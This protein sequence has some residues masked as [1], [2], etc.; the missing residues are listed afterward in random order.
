MNPDTEH[1]AIMAKLIDS[2][3]SISRSSS[4]FYYFQ[5]LTTD[6]LILRQVGM[7]D[8]DAIFVYKSNPGHKK[9][10]RVVQ[11]EYR[12][13]AEDHVFGLL[14]QHFENSSL[15]WILAFKEN[16]DQAIGNI[17]VRGLKAGDMRAQPIL[18][19]S[20][21]L[22]HHARGKGLMN[23]ARRRVIPWLFH[24]FNSMNRIHSEVVDYNTASLAMNE[25]LG[26]TREGILREYESDDAGLVNIVVLS[27]LRNEYLEKRDTK[28]NLIYLPYAEQ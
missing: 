2:K 20:C 6:R 26:F 27:L 16:P 24:Y 15:T 12:Y 25:R 18:E 23:E 1:Q 14:K 8:I 10:P 13:Q 22:A 4:A 11:F 28:G 3:K 19:I 9:V 17:T 21:E 5:E 7:S